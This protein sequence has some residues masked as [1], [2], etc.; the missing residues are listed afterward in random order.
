VLFLFGFFLKKSER[1][2][3][4]SLTATEPRIEERRT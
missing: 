4:D 2:L 1:I 3:P